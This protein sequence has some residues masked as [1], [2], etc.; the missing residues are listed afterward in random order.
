MKKLPILLLKNL[1]LLPNQEVK[2]ELNNEHS[3]NVLFLA[4]TNSNSELIVVSP[5]DQMEEMP[6][7]TDL[8]KIGVVAKVK[9]KIE[10]PNGNFRITLRGLFR[11][12]IKNF[13]NNKELEEVLEGHYKKLEIPE[14]SEVEAIA[15]KRKLTTLVHKYVSNGRGISNSILNLIKDV[16]DLNKLT[17]LI[18]GFLPIDFLRKLEY[19]SEI[20]P[21]IRGT[22]LI[23]DLHLELEVIKLDQKLDQKLQNSLEKSQKEYILKEKLKEI[24][25]E[26]GA[27]DLSKQEVLNYYTK[28]NNLTLKNPKIKEKIKNEIKKLEYMSETSPEVFNV[29]NYLDW[30]FALP[31][32][33][34]SLDETNL[35]IVKKN[36]DK[37]HYGIEKAKEK[38][39]EYIAAKNQNPKIDSPILCLIGPAGV[40]KTTFAKSIADSLNK[41]FAKISVG[42]LNDSAVLN[43][44]R[45]TYLGANPGKIIESLKRCGTNNP[46]I[47]IDEVDKM[48]RD[49]KG[50]PSSVLLDILDK[51]QN[52][53]FVDHYI[54]EEFDLSSITFILT[55]N[56]SQEIPSELLDRLEV[57]ELSSYTIFEK[58]EIAKKYIL[59]KIYK[60]HCI[61]PK[62]IKFP[63][64]I[65]K[66]II[67]GYTSEPGVRELERVLISIIRKLLVLNQTEN[68][69]INQ[70]LLK[71][72]LGEPKYEQNQLNIKNE[73]G[74]VKSLAVSNFG[75]IVLPIESV[76]YEGNGKVKVTGGIG[77]VMDE[78]IKVAISYLLANKDYFKINDYYFK[79][80]D[81]HINLLNASIKKDGPSAGIAITTLLLSLLKNEPINSSIAMTGEITL[82][83]YIGKV[84]GLKE[85]LI[86]AKDANL[87]TVFIPKSNHLD[88]ADIPKEIIDNLEIIEVE[89]YKEI[90]KIIFGGLNN[91]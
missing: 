16:K 76:Y 75:G 41:K 83:G 45:R 47:L 19:V 46:L 81:I 57:V 24:Q 86:G 90:A 71:N 27:N 51:S 87:K 77:E 67:E 37:S 89:N 40:G 38:V 61:W 49:Y 88:L 30:M 18:A 7:V 65:L 13:N 32:N 63:D 84:G 25:E 6:E 5:K 44:H 62:N 69:K 10:L 31:W 26:L 78:S 52:K 12:K 73:V 79:T 11:I 17:D 56:Q 14:F 53:T 85:K 1:L 80:K 28:L 64:A 33:T 36:L 60:D 74:V 55:A 8:P 35:E 34:T 91:E 21:I 15:L 50:N 43:G 68:I 58:Q 72:L 48:V 66:D 23:E 39:L 70:E 3:K 22:N 20:N 2:L 42:G 9:S 54:E 59:P 82:N 29:R 4:T